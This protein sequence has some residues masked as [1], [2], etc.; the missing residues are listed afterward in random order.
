MLRG[1]MGPRRLSEAANATRTCAKRAA[2]QPTQAGRVVRASNSNSS[3]RMTDRIWSQT[4]ADVH[5]FGISMDTFP[6]LTA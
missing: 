4:S 2:L 3:L 1:S 5:N 6:A